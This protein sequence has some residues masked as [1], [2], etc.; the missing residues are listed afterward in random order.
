MTQKCRHPFPPPTPTRQVQ[1]SSH[2]CLG[3]REGYAEV[4]RESCTLAHRAQTMLAL[5]LFCFCSANLVQTLE[6]SGIVPVPA[7]GNFSLPCDRYSKLIPLKV[8]V[9]VEKSKNSSWVKLELNSMSVELN[10]S[11]PSLTL[12]E[13]VNSLH[14]ISCSAYNKEE[15]MSLERDPELNN[16]TF[17]P[18]KN[19]SIFC[20]ASDQWMTLKWFQQGHLIAMVTRAGRNINI[21][22]VREGPSSIS[23][24]TVVSPDSE[25][26]K[27]GRSRRTTQKKTVKKVLLSCEAVT[28]LQ[29]FFEEKYWIIVAAVL[30][31]ILFCLAVMWGYMII[32]RRR[33]AEKQRRAKARF[34]KVSTARNLYTESINQEPANW[35]QDGMYQ[36]FSLTKDTSCDHF[37]N[38][39]S[40]LDPSEDGDSYLEP[41]SPEE[42]DQISDDGDCYENAN[43]QLK[44]GSIGSL[45]Y[46]DMNGPKNG[47]SPTPGNNCEEDADSYENMQTPIYSQLNRS[48]N[49]LG[50]D[51]ED[52]IEQT[53]P[54]MADIS[55]KQQWPLSTELNQQDGDFYLSYQA[56]IF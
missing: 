8:K 47:Q 42:A 46:E 5:L 10:T 48:V 32:R 56:T 53:G 1:A 29:I 25:N 30:G 39:S 41:M 31:Y 20:N 44:E 17:D 36:N 28:G 13:T 24:T 21:Q 50:H 7:E 35:K 3:C 9:V 51:I 11:G 40:F 26:H 6:D 23:I 14:K 38:K 43:E 54:N 15:Q 18:G 16:E 12:S 4:I 2:G 55:L 45:S 49:S 37:S 34:F 33:E 22:V 52:G 27:P 19:K